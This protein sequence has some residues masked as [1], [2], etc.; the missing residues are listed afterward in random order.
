MSNVFTISNL[1]GGQIHKLSAILMFMF[2]VTVQAQGQITVSQDIT[3][4]TTW[5]LANSPVTIT[6]TITIA[7]GATLTIDPGVEV[8]LGNAVSVLVDGGLVADGTDGNPI[9]FTSASATKAAGDWGTIE[10]RNTANVGSVINYVTMEYGSGGERAG[11]LFYTTGAFGVNISNSTF[12]F[13]ASHGVNLRASSPA[14]SNS[15]FTANQGYG[16]FTDLSLSYQVTGSTISNN[17]QG[18][19]RVPINAS[20][21]IQDNVIESNGI[22]ILIDNG[23]QPDILNNQILTNTVGIRVIEVGATKPTIVNNT[24]S[25]NMDWGIEH[26]GTVELIA[27]F[28][29]WGSSSGPTVGSNTSGL[30]DKVTFGIVE[31]TPW[32]FG[33]TDLPVISVTESINTDTVWETGNVYHVENSITV[34]ANRTLTIQPGTVV[35]FSAGA[36]MQVSGTLLANGAADNLIIFTSILDDAAGGDSNGDGD[37]SIPAPGDWNQIDITSMSQNSSLQHVII[38][39][40]GSGSNSPAI[41]A[42]APFQFTDVAVTNN[43]YEGIRVSSEQSQWTRLKINNNLR[44]GLAIATNSFNITDIET[45]YNGQHGTVIGGTNATAGAITISELVASNNAMRGLTFDRNAS[46]NIA[47]SSIS[48]SNFSNNGQDGVYINN[49]T[50]SLEVTG[51]TFDK[52]ENHGLFLVHDGS[53]E[54][55]AISGNTFSGNGES[56][57]VST[58]ARFIDNTFVGN[59][60]SIGATGRLGHRYTDENGVDGNT[61]TDNT[62]NN[63]L[64]LYGVNL[65]D[66]LS[67]VFPQAID[68]KSYI[69]AANSSSS[70]S[71]DGNTVVIDPGVTVKVLSGL[72]ISS[73]SNW[74]N[75]RGTL[76]AVGTTEEP[77]V[78]TSLRDDNYGG[79]INIA[80][81]TLAAAPADWSGLEVTSLGSIASRLEHVVIRYANTGLTVGHPLGSGFTQTDYEHPIRALT[82]EYNGTNGLNLRYGSLTLDGARIEQNGST[83]VVLKGSANTTTRM[84][85]RNAE[86]REN[87][88]AT[89]IDTNAGLLAQSQT[90]FTEI[91]NSTIEGNR[92]GI[93]MQSA[94]LPITLLG[95]NILNNEGYGAHVIS[96]LSRE[97]HAYVGNTFSGNGESGVVSTQA[98]FIDNTFVGN[99][100]S[101][102]ATGRL[103]H[104]YTDENGV[105]GNTFTDNTYNNALALYGVNLSDTLS[106]V[107]PQAIDSKSYIVAANSSS[108]LSP[109][110]NTVVIDPGVTVKVLS[111]LGISS[112]SNWLNFRGTLTAVGTTEEPIVFTSLR[113]DNYGGDINI[114]SDTLAA[115]PADWSGLEVTSLGSIASRLEHVVIRYANTGLTVGHP[116]GSGFTQTDYEH[117][118]RALTLEYNGTNGLNLRYGSLTLD[119]ARIEQN[120]STGVVLKGSANTTTRMVIRNAEI[121]ENG[122]ATTIDTNAG[123][124]AQSQTVFTEIS[125]STIEGNRNGIIMQ[126]AM[127]PSVIQF[128]QIQDNLDRGLVGYFSGVET[129]T[130]FTVTG[131]QINR[132]G[133]IGL[134]STRAIVTDNQF[135]GNQFTIGVAGELSKPETVNDLGNFY[136]GNTFANNEYENVKAVFSTSLFGLNGK[137]GFSY[138]DAFE[139]PV[140][141]SISSSNDNVV[142]GDTLDIGPG[143][144]L[145]FG[146]NST[147]TGISSSGLLR[148][149]GEVDRKIVFTT[150]SDDTYGG[151]TNNDSTATVPARS[152]WGGITLTGADTEG[153]EFR[154]AILRY[155]GTALTVDQ[156]AEVVVDSSFISNSA[157][158]LTS[159]RNGVLTVRNSDIHTNRDGITINADAGNPVIQLNNIYDNEFGLRASRNLSAINNYWGDVT[160]PFVNQGADPNTEGEGNAIV[161]SNES[162]AATYRPFLGARTGIQLG[163]VSDNGT[164]SAFDA[165][166]ILQHVVELTELTPPQLAAADVTGDGQVSALDASFVLQFVVGNISG[167]PG[168]GKQLPVNPA[169]WLVYDMVTQHE[170]TDILIGTTGALPLQAAD[171]ALNYSSA[172]YASAEYLTGTIADDWIREFNVQ[173]SSIHLAQAG[174]DANADAGEVI[175]LRLYFHEHTR[176]SEANDIEITRLRFNEVSLEDYLNELISTEIEQGSLPAA[177]ALGNNYPNPFN[178]S[179]VIP[180]QLAAPGDVSVTVYNTLGQQVAVLMQGQ[181]HAAGRFEVNFDASRLSSGVYFYVVE[182]REAEGTTLRAVKPMTL[183]K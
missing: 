169:D 73:S 15:E 122:L 167:F 67:A 46:W 34:G 128:N 25:G 27:R 85:I 35:K 62:Y 21:T 44:S 16:I 98:R 163:D 87:G 19:I 71:P 104:R 51:S 93:I 162:I 42:Q 135:E 10:F 142:A 41:H 8:R 66:T 6:E 115:A 137:L 109:D 180:F 157:T 143:S 161:L 68:S 139:N 165:S 149:I 77:I 14:I 83:G 105:D 20:P 58:Q 80:S 154:H 166:L 136:E 36:S 117:P 38:R 3:S 171:I 119:G 11:Q 177:F 106:A 88:L 49:N 114:A 76:T 132:N 72:G 125:N 172:L 24:I 43:L 118:I 178:P 112:S 133:T 146:R 37:N 84:V 92:N 130:V 160:G 100:F 145:K 30:G 1:I 174:M 120:G 181:A 175:R 141:V 151:D 164:I 32:R 123:L 129:D 26:L 18:G 39:F 40:A 47:I 33:A 56:G 53:R 140:I 108:S 22:G 61:F 150:F 152:N 159:R 173:E 121:R 158:G 86:I 101:I 148:A 96:Q 113:D 23:G 7:S 110:G 55:L 29:F 89:T 64:A 5:T 182:V 155:A 65:S 69:V 60:F 170:Y 168:A 147:V 90:V 94:M 176:G 97:D 99:R 79:D 107:F 54:N 153:S 17:S 156:S 78:F 48:A 111:G 63:A 127:L 50:G 124:L 116:L 12:R 2:F 144:V 4:N 45:S 82:L 138:P 59:R 91:S 131:N 28:N 31:F 179:T 57:V 74:L 126:S 102:G 13:S 134:L 9:V 52:N 103:G 183:M 75:F 70:L 95:N 81:D